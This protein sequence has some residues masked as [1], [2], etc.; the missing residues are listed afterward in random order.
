MTKLFADL[1]FS[2]IGYEF[3]S[4]ISAFRKSFELSRAALA[5]EAARIRSDLDAYI[6]GDEFIG[7]RT[8]DGHTI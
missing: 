8:E 1:T 7:E 5:A 2:V 3:E 4:S 6:A